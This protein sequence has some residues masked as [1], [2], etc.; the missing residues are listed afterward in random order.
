MENIASLP[1]IAE[2]KT[3][4]IY[5]NPDDPKTV[6]MFFKDTIT[7]GDGLKRDI[8]KGKAVLDWKIN[9]DIYEYLNRLGIRTHYIAS[10]EE[11][12]CLV[13]R[14]N[15]KI[16]LEVVGR[17]I[18]AGS[19]IQWGN[20]IEGTKYDPVIVQF[21]YKDDDLHDPMLDDGYINYLINAKGSTE[22][23]D[24]RAIN[25]VVLL[26]LE[27]AFA[28]FGIQILDLKLEYGIIER[29]VYVIDEISGGSLRLWPYRHANPDLWRPNVLSE[30]NPEARLDKDTY[31]MG[32]SFDKVIARFEK[33]AEITEQFKALP[34]N[35]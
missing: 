34:N 26:H 4:I 7:A 13:K 20:A 14:L 23:T 1:V 12:V 22:Y 28:Q 19:I 27:K 8:I 24:M 15:R 32:E 17:R 6:Y 31:R 5:A 33:I 21:H 9:R 18:A 2:G 25:T 11:R 10:P 30:L 16:N 35:I 3:K 29:Q